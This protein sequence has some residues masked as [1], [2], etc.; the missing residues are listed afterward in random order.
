MPYDILR[1]FVTAGIVALIVCIARFDFTRRLD[2]VYVAIIQ[3][4]NAG[5]VCTNSD[6]GN[7]H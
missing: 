6:N 5:H 4:F 3:G 7:Q 1:Q 2:A